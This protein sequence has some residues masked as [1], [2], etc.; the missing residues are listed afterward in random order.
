MAYGYTNV[1]SRAQV[2]GGIIMLLHG[3]L[4][5]SY[6]VSSCIWLPYVQKLGYPQCKRF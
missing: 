3:L 1:M 6:L 4:V 2:T 5:M